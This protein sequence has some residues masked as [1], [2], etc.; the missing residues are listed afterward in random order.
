MAQVASR[1]HLQDL[2]NF[3]SVLNHIV[4]Q[5]EIDRQGITLYALQSNG[6]ANNR[7]GAQTRPTVQLNSECLNC[8]SKNK[9]VITQAFKMACLSYSPSQIRIDEQSF[10]RE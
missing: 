2:L 9:A 8:E 7:N 3:S 4:I 1:S 6:N 5:D 10:S